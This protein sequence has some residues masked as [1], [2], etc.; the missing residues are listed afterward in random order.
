M[1][2]NKPVEGSLKQDT[3]WKWLYRVLQGAI[4][5]TGA[6][7]PG[8]SGGVLCVIF[9]IYRPM[10]ALLSHPIRTFKIHAKL[11]FP[12][13]IG[14]VAG[15]I[16]LAKVVK[17]IFESN[18]TIAVW[19][20]IGLIAGM[21]PSLFKEAGKK[22]RT[23]SSW[24]TLIVSTIAI[25]GLLFFLQ[26][27]KSVNIQPTVFWFFISGL[28]W[29]VSLVLPGMSSS[30]ILIFLGL[31]APLAAGIGSLSPEV[32]IPWLIGLVLVLLL[33][34][35]AINYLFDRHYAVAFNLILGFVI[36][37]TLAIVPLEFKNITETIICM[38][39]FVVGF[40][41]AW[42]MDRL[43]EKIKPKD[44]EETSTT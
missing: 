27:S 32:I 42:L 18:Y 11:L 29:G 16:G 33:S 8:I 1:N 44:D 15:F 38:A 17:L 24:V 34:A 31:Y 40:V 2:E 39:C 37:S 14:F 7:L 41:I 22:G 12:V 3:I 36:A 10:M 30:S 6:I 25:F 20:F 28:F 35:R 26:N 13:L 43:G 4:I 21:I 5:G 9:G 23:I 19:L